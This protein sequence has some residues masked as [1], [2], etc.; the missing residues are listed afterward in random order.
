MED[1]NVYNVTAK[2]LRKIDKTKDKSSTRALLA[3]TGNQLIKRS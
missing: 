3:I 1:L 2:I